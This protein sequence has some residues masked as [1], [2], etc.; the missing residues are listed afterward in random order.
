M[1]CFIVRS[2][3][4]FEIEDDLVCFVQQ[5]SLNGIKDYINKTSG[6]TKHT[7]EDSIKVAIQEGEIEI[8]RFLVD[9]GCKEMKGKWSADIYN[10]LGSATHYGKKELIDLFLD[11]GLFDNIGFNNYEPSSVIT[12]TQWLSREL[13]D[14]S[15]NDIDMFKFILTKKQI[16]E[17]IS[18]WHSFLYDIGGKE[19]PEFAEIIFQKDV[20][21]KSC[22][23]I[24]GLCQAVT[25]GY[26]K[27]AQAFLDHGVPINGKNCSQ[28]TPIHV[29][30][31]ERNIEAVKF[32][33]AQGADINIQDNQGKTALHYALHLGLFDIV[34]LLVDKG[35]SV[36]IKDSEG[37]SPH[38]Y[39]QEMYEYEKEL[40]KDGERC[41]EELRKLIRVNLSDQECKLG[42][43]EIYENFRNGLLP[44]VSNFK[45][46]DEKS[47]TL[48]ELFDD[49]PSL[50]QE[51]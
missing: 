8:T 11:N 10:P 47:Y 32:L 37:K 7:L 24:S 39:L 1:S 50:W 33:L 22:D 36:S 35:A 51:I 29:A 18:D 26:F 40:F 23:A 49:P 27:T 41:K 2:E 9:I 14:C 17:S 31:E 15:L 19:N 13:I 30:V 12:V 48:D 16:I 20:N 34:H 5:G 21:P 3:N 25:K 46:I 38:D 4:L 44:L 43:K 42:L 28:Q 6:I 45:T